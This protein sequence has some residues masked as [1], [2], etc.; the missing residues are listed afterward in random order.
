MSPTRT[1]IWNSPAF[2]IERLED[3]AP[4]A[5]IFHFTGPFIANDMYRS[6]KPAVVSGIF[7]FKPEPGHEPPT[8]HIF[9]LTEVPSMDS[10]GLGL[11][12]SHYMNCRSRGIRVIAVGVSQNVQQ[13]LHFTRVDS[14]IPTAATVEEAILS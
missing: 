5:L 14:L 2:T 10:S 1:P 9:D 11:I 12:V 13:L 3:K 8:I 7:E 6:L 4:R